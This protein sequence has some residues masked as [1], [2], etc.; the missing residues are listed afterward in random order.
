MG[1][2]RRVHMGRI[3]MR[4]LHQQI[5][6]EDAMSNHLWEHQGGKIHTH[7]Q[8]QV[9]DFGWGWQQDT[10]T[11][12]IWGQGQ[13]PGLGSAWGGLDTTS[14][15]WPCQG[16]GD[17]KVP[18]IPNHS[19][20]PL[21][22]PAVCQGEIYPRNHSPKSVQP[23]KAQGAGAT[24]FGRRIVPTPECPLAESQRI[25]RSGFSRGEWHHSHFSSYFNNFF[26]NG[27]DILTILNIP[28][29]IIWNTHS[30]PVRCSEDFEMH[31]SIFLLAFLII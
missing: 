27:V 3:F 8:R 15:W 28:T 30:L 29:L 18:S 4:G 24:F 11:A 23:R 16:L 26:P 21:Q 31:Y 7:T 22:F 14:S 6:R 20:I 10:A 1:N 19:V 25:L 13:T 5:R 17:F 9:G 12:V 2:E